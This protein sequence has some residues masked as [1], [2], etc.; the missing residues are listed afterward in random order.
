MEAET[1]AR[2]PARYGSS[3][4]APARATQDRIDIPE[5]AP[6]LLPSGDISAD[7]F[8][9]RELS[10][11]HFNARVL[12]LA[13]DPD[14]ALLERV[15]F[16][17]IFASNLDEFFMVRVA[18]LKRRIATGLAVPS[19]AGLSPIEQLETIMADGLAL[20]RRHAAIFAEHIRPALTG[21]NIHLTTWDELDEV[22]RQDLNKLFAEKVFPILTPLAVDPAHPFPYISGLSLNLAVVVRN[23]VSDKELFARVKVPDQLPRLISSTTPSGLP[24]MK[25]SR[26]RRM[27]PRTCC[28][29]SRRSCCGVGSA[30]PSGLRSPRTSTPASAPCSP[31]SLV[32]RMRRSMTCPLPW[33]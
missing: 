26:L 5:F 1:A 10:W 4:V 17:S 28:R 15:N 20:Q 19:A 16:L 32:L 11:L 33:T 8:L 2:V 9:D 12:D 6:S 31:A 22:A 23:P 18:G 25:T 13:E 14:L 27:T 7:R 24:A 3:E 21:E 29:R 30:R